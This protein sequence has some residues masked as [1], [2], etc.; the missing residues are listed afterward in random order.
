MSASSSSSLRAL[1]PLGTVSHF[2]PLLAGGVAF[3]LVVLATT[4][5]VRHPAMQ[6][7]DRVGGLLVIGLCVCWVATPQ[8]WPR[9]L[10]ALV[11]LWFLFAPLVFWEAL[12]WSAI[13]DVVAGSLF[14]TAAAILPTTRNQDHGD[15]V[16]PGWD[17]NPSAWSQRLPILGLACAGF[18]MSGHL[19]AFQLGW[20]DQPWDPLFG[21]G[22]Q[23]VLTSDISHWFPVSDAGLGALAYLLE[24]L[25][26]L[27]GDRRRWRTM[28]WMVLLFGVMIIPT[29]AVSIVL[30]VLQPIGVGSWCLLC[31]ATAVVMLLM[32]TPSLD[33]VIATWQ[34]LRRCRRQGGAW[35]RAL[36]HGVDERDAGA[37]SA[38]VVPASGTLPWHLVACAVAATWLMAAPAVVGTAGTIA[39]ANDHLS[40]A[41]AVSVAVIA[42]GEIARPLRWLLLPVGCWLVI[43]SWWLPGANVLSVVNAMVIGLLLVAAGLRRGQVVHRFG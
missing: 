23:R 30:V 42:C 4:P 12:A 41:V 7:G 25:T 37:V 31:L 24:A 1:G 36:W 17:Y 2:G 5:L 16:P 35:Q 3:L 28:P 15:E 21:S 13:V 8:A 27:I 14:I 11:G 22:T 33:E 32:V 26:C 19:A 10:V 34:A 18:L 39:A 40:G 9:W 20:I 29:G 43:G 6:M 38:R